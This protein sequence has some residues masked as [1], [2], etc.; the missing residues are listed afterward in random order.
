[1]ST[2][3][4]SPIRPRGAVTVRAAWA[5]GT[6]PGPVTTT[7]WI[8]A[9]VPTGM[10]TTTLNAPEASAVVVPRLTGSLNS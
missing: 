7:A 4:S 3:D 8:P 5:R 10:V 2:W 6:P 1:M 9:G